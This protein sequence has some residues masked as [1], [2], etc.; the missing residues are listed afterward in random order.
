MRHQ[1]TQHRSALIWILSVVLLGLFGQARL[2]LSADDASP[3]ALAKPR[4]AVKEPSFDFGNLS[5]NR[6]VRHGFSVCNE[7]NALLHIRDITTSC[8]CTTTSHQALEIEPGACQTIEAQ[9]NPLRFDGKVLKT[10]TLHTNDP[11]Q[12]EYV[13]RLSAFIHRPLRASQDFISF[14][15][16]LL[17]TT[18][19]QTVDIRST[20]GQPFAITGWEIVPASY[21]VSIGEPTG[22]RTPYKRLALLLEDTQQRG[23]RTGRLVVHTDHPD[24]ATMEL[25]LHANVRGRVELQPDIVYV[26]TGRD[27]PA[28]R[29]VEVT[30]TMIPDLQVTR[31]STDLDWLVP[32]LEQ[33]DNSWRLRLAVRGLGL[34]PGTFRQ[35]KVVVETNVPGE[36]RLELPVTVAIRPER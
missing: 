21:T 15:D 10:L 26:I 1:A 34:D 11:E 6:V 25:Q 12:A 32:I 9:F 5:P 24:Q 31:V 36:T 29:V 19:V 22:T 27:E 4:L 35:G 20:N 7:G 23:L 3:A 28:E 13:L 18:A 8:G 2:V 17:G 14:R 30:S 16:V 33:T